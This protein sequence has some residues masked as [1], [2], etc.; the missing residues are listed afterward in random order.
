MK[1]YDNGLINCFHQRLPLPDN[2]TPVSLNEG[3]TPLIRL[4]N[5][6]QRQALDMDI[7]VKYEGANPSGS[8][9]DR[10]MT[11]AV[12]QALLE[13]KHALICASTG[14]T[15]ASA[16]AYAARAGMRA[17]V[18]VPDGKI[19]LGK[20]AQAIIKGAVIV[21][22]SGNFDQG[23][24]L[25]K[26]LAD[27]LPLALVN[28]VNPYRLQ[29][30]KTAAFE[31]IE[32]LGTAPD[33]HCLPVGNAGNITA[34]WMGYAEA[35]GRDSDCI[36]RAQK[37][38]NGAW[39][40]GPPMTDTL[41][42]MLGYQAQGSAPIL[43]GKKIDHPETVATAIRIGNPQSWKQA[44]TAARESGGWFNEVSDEEILTAQRMLASL[45]GIFCE[46]ASAAS[47]AGLLKDARAGRI[48]KHS[49]VVCTLT[50]HG[51]KDSAVAIAHGQDSMIRIKPDFVAVKQLLAARI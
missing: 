17:F 51:L 40:G 16:A 28:S 6:P 12:T 39:R 20:L 32:A 3:G 29:G 13:E 26:D 8:F 19:A 30:Q 23:M 41:P 45:E 14:N 46:P 50:G 9:K 48:K 43:R 35:A 42:R 18:L 44:V 37:S 36:R 2:V 24:V 49:R 1:R 34:Y 4:K 21:Q 11:V 5:L 27:D 38:L 25:V 22:I 31:I 33:Y 15:S 10:G 7:F 47:I